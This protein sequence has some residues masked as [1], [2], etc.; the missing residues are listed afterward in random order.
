MKALG[1]TVKKKSK[2]V[3]KAIADGMKEGLQTGMKTFNKSLKSDIQDAVKVIKKELKIKSP[4]RVMR[5]EVGKNMALGIGVGFSDEM[6]AVTQQMQDSVP[7]TFDTSTT[8]N[9]MQK[10][11][12][13][14]VGA[15]KEALSQM[16]VELDDDKVGR[17]V[18]K[19]VTRE[20]YA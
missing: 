6:K 17:F 8:S 18:V 13:N 1:V 3:G 9:S 15:F 11:Y 2:P 14:M 7:K 5:D 19:T 12:N 16:T 20:I 4:S 10:P